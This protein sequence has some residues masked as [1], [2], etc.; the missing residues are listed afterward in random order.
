VD[1]IGDAASYPQ[2]SR[3]VLTNGAVLQL[4]A[5]QGVDGG[6][7]EAGAGRAGR[8]EAGLG[9]G[10]HGVGPPVEIR[11]WIMSKACGPRRRSDGLAIL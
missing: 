6:P 4:D 1:N 10:D 11:P 5:E 7:D 3:Q 8:G 9:H 2:M